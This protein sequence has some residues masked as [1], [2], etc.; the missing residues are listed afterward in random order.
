MFP[1]WNRLL[2]IFVCALDGRE[3][4]IRQWYKRQ[5]WIEK[6]HNCEFVSMAI[7]YIFV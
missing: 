3:S 6:M 2:L 1:F 5:T 4:L 7:A